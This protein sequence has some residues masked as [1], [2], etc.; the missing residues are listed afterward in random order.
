M[1]KRVVSYGEGTWFLLPI[2]TSDFIAGVVARISRI[3]PGILSLIY[4]ASVLKGR[5]KQGRLFGLG[6]WDS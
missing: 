5:R 3:S 6:T 1:R 4:P 2:T